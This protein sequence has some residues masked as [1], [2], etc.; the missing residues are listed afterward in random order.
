MTDEQWTLKEKKK[1][2]SKKER[3][4]KKEGQRS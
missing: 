4:V 3:E 1:K 2:R